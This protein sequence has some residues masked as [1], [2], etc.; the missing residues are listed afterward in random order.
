MNP[1]VVKDYDGVKQA[2]LESLGDTPDGADKRWCTLSR[3]RGETHRALYRRVHTTGFRRM[4]GLETKEECCQKMIL[5]KFLTLLSPEC[6]SS[7]VAKRPRNGQEAASYAQEFA[8]D[9]SF[10][11]SLQP[12]PT[13]GHH[14]SQNFFS[15]REAGNNGLGSAQCNSGSSVG[16][17]GSSQGGG[18][19]SKASSNGGG[20]RRFSPTRKQDNSSTKP[21][22]QERQGQ[23]ERKPI[24]CYGCGE[25][26]HIRPNCPNKVR[27]V[28]SPEGD[29]VMEI[30]GWLA[31]SVVQG[32]RVDTGADRTIVS[33]E[34]IPEVA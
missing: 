6:Y 28:K 12:R 13:G 23:K 30:D 9:T 34:C 5:S 2:M 26:G 10:A 16:G 18:G 1:L 21:S 25:V 20:S 11:R 24:T 19:N 27:R 17:A 7:V 15:K 8:E 22:R 29:H 32:L 4:H 3:Q 14:N 31:G 33:A